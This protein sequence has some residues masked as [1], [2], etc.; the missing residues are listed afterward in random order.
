MKKI[1][2]IRLAIAALVL[3]IIGGAT[4][5]LLHVNWQEDL[6]ADLPG[7]TPELAA[8][9]AYLKSFAGREP[10]AVDVDAQA[11]AHPMADA[12][13]A[14][15]DLAQRLMVT[16][17]FKRVDTGLSLD[18]GPAL[19][20]NLASHLPGLLDPAD[21]PEVRRRL[22]G[23]RARLE[24]FRQQALHN[25]FAV[26]LSEQ[27]GRDPLG[28]TELVLA[29]L[30]WF[31][32]QNVTL[33]GS[34]LV[35]PDKRHL[36]LLA[37][38]K[39]PASDTRQGEAMLRAW[40]QAVAGAAR[41]RGPAGPVFNAIGPHRSYVD[42]ARQI[43]RDVSLSTSAS[44][45]LIITIALFAL[46]RPWQTP[47]RLLPSFIGLAAGLTAVGFLYQ[48]FS[49]IIWGMISSLLGITVDYGLHVL[50]AVQRA[51]AD[52]VAAARTVRWPVWICALTTASS[53][54]A[55]FVTHFP[56]QYRLAVFGFIGV[57]ISG[58]FAIHALPYL[59]PAHAGEA[60]PPLWNLDA[61]ASG[62]EAW[63]HRHAGWVAFILLALIL[64]A[65]AGVSRLQFEGDPESLNALSPQTR[66]AET[67]FAQAF[68]DPTNRLLT[69]QKAADPEA[70]L[71]QAEKLDVWLKSEAA[72]KWVQPTVTLAEVIPSR[73]TQVRRAEAFYREFG[74][75]GRDLVAGVRRAGRDLKFREN[76]FAAFVQT[77]AHPGEI[78][79]PED[80][81]QAGLGNML[82]DRWMKTPAGIMA[83]TPLK[84]LPGVDPAELQ[85]TI[86]AAVPGVTFLDKRG[87][88]GSI[89]NVLRADLKPAI[90][91][92]VLLVG[93]V[94]YLSKKRLE[95]TFAALL[96]LG[97]ALLL[98]LGTLA[99]LHVKINLINL[100]A[101]PALLGIG[102]NYTVFR[103][104]CAL[105]QYKGTRLPAGSILLTAIETMAGFGALLLAGHPALRSVGVA[106]VVGVAWSLICALL[107]VPMIMNLFLTREADVPP[108]SL[109]TFLGGLL[110]Y[111]AL[112]FAVV[113]YLTAVLPVLWVMRWFKREAT[114]HF[115]L[116]VCSYIIMHYFPYGRRLY[117]Q[118]DPRRLASP[119]ILVGNHEAQVDILLVLSLSANLHAVV[120]PWVW[121]HPI[122]G[123]MVRGAGFLLAT[124]E[125]ARQVLDESAAYLHAGKSL[126][127]YPEGSRARDGLMR[128]FHKGAFQLSV[129][130]GFPI[131]PVA[132]VNTRTCTADNTWFIGNHAS[133]I[134]LL[135]PMRP[136]DFSGEDPATQMAR[137]ARRRIEAARQRLWQETCPDWVVRQ[138]I[139][140]RYL[141]RDALAETYVSWKLRLD[142]VYA[143]VGKKLPLR[144]R[145]IDLGCGHGL[146]SHW[147]AITGYERPV[148]GIDDDQR[149]IALAK[150]TQHY[151]RHLRFECADIL[152]WQGEP[153]E[154]VLML[155]ILHYSRPEVQARMLQKGT[156]LLAPQG[157]LYVREGVQA[158]GAYNATA[159]G[160]VFSTGIGFNKK[161]DGL[162][163]A[164]RAGWEAR[165][166]AAGLEIESVEICGPGKSN[167]LFVLKGQT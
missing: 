156:A 77:L 1:T 28:L 157:R 127:I 69:L 107:L 11:C 149:K 105:A 104:E 134:T 73:A 40:D 75:Q 167:H 33:E 145:V 115:Y 116:H 125:N 9:R 74:P 47:L 114:G 110:I 66:L 154:A 122:L 10:L 86:T 81:F 141:Y 126:V 31:S 121:N 29:K 95:L 163:F 67:R 50:M 4:F 128:R 102:V 89:L 34:R 123:P 16:G 68:G 35:S 15:D 8:A 132:L 18:S 106:L 143:A 24:A 91:W 111:G 139:R 78:L 49:L 150:Q 136:E 36:L 119:C 165:F 99:W 98:T 20:D 113:F 129:E 109:K 6:L 76:A 72:R 144:A 57:L 63:G 142:P 62:M 12:A 60:K 151:Q 94:V 52:P 58:A 100:A 124:G 153:A 5:S 120:K 137:E 25:P 23:A 148:T 164:D 43:K 56:G 64:W 38:P 17:Y 140:E 71:L 93:L 45:I 162:F 96:P 161:R 146:M 83:A 55:L 159:G 44:L 27:V 112:L 87:L 19:W 32:T 51:P 21:Y 84:P 166:R 37:Y 80:F 101:A 118:F 92:A 39:F 135:E 82:T 130:T 133:L 13:E 160:E 158:A 155:D 79:V 30:R 108:R 22:L 147:A 7:N 59:I 131:Q 46:R 88:A 26:G 97:V 103:I 70:A 90:L 61:W 53:F 117:Y 14:A 138:R 3:A 54:L 85:R 152:D 65:G 42:N 41:T 2:G 48:S